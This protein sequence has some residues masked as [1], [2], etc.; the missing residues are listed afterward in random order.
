MFLLNDHMIAEHNSPNGILEIAPFDKT[1]LCPTYYYF[2]LGAQY[3]KWIKE[4]STW[5]P[6]DLSQGNEILNVG[7]N[8]Y[9]LIQSYERFRCSKQILAIFG[10]SS[11]LTRK[12]IKLVHSPFV[13]PN[14]PAPDDAGY[15]ELG[16]K[17]EL[18]RPVQLKFRERIGKICFYNVADTYPIRDITG[19][20][21]EEDFRRRQGSGGPLPLYDDHP[22]PGW[23]DVEKGQHQ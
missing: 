22:A 16:L 17:N 13:D 1:A 8:E 14:F 4:T 3:R 5:Q 23:Q 9:L 6:R 11:A 12:G 15:L 21:S 20:A 7:A 2:R 10:Q 18:D 19:T